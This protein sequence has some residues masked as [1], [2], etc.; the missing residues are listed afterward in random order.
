MD[1]TQAIYRAK[2]NFNGPSQQPDGQWQY[3]QRGMGMQL[4]SLKYPS[5]KEA[6]SAMRIRI[7]LVALQLYGVSLFDATKWGYTL[8]EI[9]SDE[10]LVNQLESFLQT[11]TPKEG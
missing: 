10:E 11:Y 3:F 9:H 5:H 2:M 4:P 8:K 1:I 6:M 7:A